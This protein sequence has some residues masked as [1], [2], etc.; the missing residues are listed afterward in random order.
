VKDMIS[1]RCFGWASERYEGEEKESSLSTSDQ[2]H[3]FSTC[4]LLLCCFV[5]VFGNLS[6]ADPRF[7]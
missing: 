3:D 2:T 7:Q 6:S 4:T 5:R 1:E